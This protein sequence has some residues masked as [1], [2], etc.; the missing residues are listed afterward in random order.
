M[1]TYI[2]ISDYVEI[3]FEIPLLQNR[4]NIPSEILL[5]NS[6]AVRNI[7]FLFTIWGPRLTGGDGVNA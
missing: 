4:P 6:E 1:Y 2:H 5:N 7:E 3:I